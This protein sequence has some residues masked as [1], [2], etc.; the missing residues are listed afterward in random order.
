YARIGA[1]DDGRLWATQLSERDGKPMGKPFEITHQMLASQ[2]IAMQ[3]P[4]NYVQ[5]LQKFQ[6]TNAQIELAHAHAGYYQDL[7]EQRREAAALRAQT[8]E[9]AIEQRRQ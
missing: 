3:T 6:L 4:S 1:T 2:I 9:D 8:Q 5:A 7:P